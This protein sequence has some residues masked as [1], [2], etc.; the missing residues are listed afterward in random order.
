MSDVLHGPVPQLLATLV[1]VWV[2][3]CLLKNDVRKPVLRSVAILVLGDVG[4]S[5]RMMYHAESF[6]KHGFETY[7]IGYEG[8]RPIPSLLS[9]PHIHLT[10]LPGPPS[11]L[12]GFP[13]IVLAPF[14]VLHQVISILHAL[15]G[16]IP[17][18]PEFILVQ[19]PPSI[20]TLALVWFVGQWQGS[21]VIIDWHNLGYSILA[22]KLG[23]S[24]PFVRLARKFEVTFGRHAYAHLF[25]TRAMHDHLSKEW[26]L[27][28][29]KVVLHD[30]PPAHFHRASEFETH[31]LFLHLVPSLSTPSLTSF[32]PPSTPP[33]STPFT[34]VTDVTESSS[35]KSLPSP[36]PSPTLNM[37]SLRPDR[38][39][40]L[41]SSTS[42]T[43]DEDFSILL[44]ALSAYEKRA[45][46]RRGE[47]PK[48]LAI[49]TGR[50]P[51]K[52]RYMNEVGKL[53]EEWEWVRCLS[54]WLEAEDYPV[55]LGSADLGVSLHS[56]SSALDLPMKIVDMFGCGL[57]VCALDFACL[58]ELV[59]ESTNGLIFKDVAQLADQLETL[60]TSFPSSE[61]LNSL[62]SSIMKSSDPSHAARD[63]GLTGSEGEHWEWNSWAENWDKVMMPLILRDIQGRS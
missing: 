49:V 4:R 37:P 42:W 8:A 2:V 11:L 28:G 40:L 54:L 19:N 22:L 9:L 17:H 31:E 26:Q 10:Y 35:I 63:L 56:S 38:P 30:R 39:A 20:P 33:Y 44:A 57:P 60:L 3:W 62:R 23:K 32:L 21:K 53:Q 55:L 16:R 47:L 41:V 15:L 43:P 50:G 58:H 1:F 51:L 45:R 5:P 12:L 7:L 29:H 46:E 36:A 14:K 13:F 59:K 52:E 34:H 24:H 6:T 61:A 18:P 27:I 48:V 25:V